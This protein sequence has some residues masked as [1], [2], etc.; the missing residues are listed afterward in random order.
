MG[1]FSKLFGRKPK[2]E[3]PQRTVRESM[4][5]P[6]TT[7]TPRPYTPT[8]TRKAA[9]TSSTSRS[10]S[11]RNNYDDPLTNPVHPLNPTWSHSSSNSHSHDHSPSQS[12]SSSSSYSDSSSS[13]SDSG[14]CGGSSD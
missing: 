8:V 7:A 10:E 5:S 9:P 13:S 2:Q 4:G 6:R 14:S 11:S 3:Q 1:F 12:C